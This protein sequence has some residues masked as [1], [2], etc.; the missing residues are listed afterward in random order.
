MS[1]Q[2][3][4]I[5]KQLKVIARLDS[6]LPSDLSDEDYK[7]YQETLDEKHLGLAEDAEVTRFIMRGELDFNEQMALRDAMVVMQNKGEATIKL[8]AT[9]LETR[10][11]LCGI[12][13]HP[14]N[15]R[16]IEFKLD[17]DKLACLELCAKLAS[18]GVLD[19]IG[20][21]RTTYIKSQHKNENLKKK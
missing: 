1:I 5:P 18:Q 21:T 4:A 14:N 20:T 10:L 12:E 13:N 15:P 6:G 17:I 9:M 8:S 16:P 2:D 11:A 7:L 19:Q 3:F